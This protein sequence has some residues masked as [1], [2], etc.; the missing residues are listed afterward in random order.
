L[1]CCGFLRGQLCGPLSGQ[2]LRLLRCHVLGDSTIGGGFDFSLLF[3]MFFGLL[4]RK[5]LN[6]QLLGSHTVSGSLLG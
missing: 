5:L 4:F 6:R 3:G 2:L 1:P